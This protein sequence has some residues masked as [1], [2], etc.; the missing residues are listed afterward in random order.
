MRRPPPNDVPGQPKLA[1]K[2]SVVQL[3][4]CG[5]GY[6][7][8]LRFFSSAAQLFQHGLAVVAGLVD[9]GDPL[10]VDGSAAFFHAAEL[11]GEI[12]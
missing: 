1:R 3:A 5:A 10:V 7:S 9:V 6:C 2:L 8:A 12:G 4:S 11:L